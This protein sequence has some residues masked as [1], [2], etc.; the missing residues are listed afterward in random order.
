MAMTLEAWLLMIIVGV[1]ISLAC[2]YFDSGKR[3]MLC[4]AGGLVWLIVAVNSTSVNV[5][6]EYAISD[7]LKEFTYSALIMLFGFI[8]VIHFL[9][10]LYEAFGFA[11]Q[12]VDF[13]DMSI[14]RGED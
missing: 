5:I 1:A 13:R 12:N 11:Q 4:F 10:I 7:Y 6:I 3:I 8:S 2:V 9:Y 14:K